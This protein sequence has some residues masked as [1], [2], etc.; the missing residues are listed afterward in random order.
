MTILIIAVLFG[1]VVSACVAF[2]N[3]CTAG[4]LSCLNNDSQPANSG[5]KDSGHCR[6]EPKTVVIL[7]L[8]GADPQLSDCLAG[9]LQQDYESWE[10]RIVVDHAD[11][12]SLPAVEQFLAGKPHSNVTVRVLENRR[13]TCS[14]KLSALSQELDLISDECEAV[15][16]LDADVMTYPG[17]L[18]DMVTPL[19][20][21]QIGA[22]TGLR[23]FIPPTDSIGAK[24]RYLWNLA[25]VGQM[26]HF[27]IA[28]GGSLA[29]RADF[30]RSASLS[31]AWTRMVFEDTALAVSLDEA[32]LELSFVPNA[33]MANT[34]AI[35]CANFVRFAQRQML[36]TRLYHPAWKIIYM[37]GVFSTIGTAG[38]LVATPVA[39]ITLNW[40]AAAIF[41]CT[42][43][44]ATGFTAYYAIRLDSSVRHLLKTHSNQDLASALPRSFP[45]L[46]LVQVLYCFALLIA[47]RQK[48]VNWRGIQY[49]LESIDGDCHV[50]MREYRPIERALDPVSSIV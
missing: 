32:G 13:Q 43:A 2:Q 47:L 17:W 20:N 50:Q 6:F 19:Q 25:A 24:V 21:E 35:G 7:C 1:V 11:D 18:R 8:R 22:T 41:A 28:W 14:L 46:V 45:Y 9:L 4:L 15:V 23:W 26:H 31:D 16:L 38:M 30:I 12:P 48:T 10:L 36:N 3:H 34:E 42:I 49:D 39:L 29:M 40:A 27:S 37:H 33:V 44:V 5:D